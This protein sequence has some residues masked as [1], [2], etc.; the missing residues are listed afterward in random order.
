MGK[1]KS[2]KI[3]EFRK[4]RIGQELKINDVVVF[5]PPRYKGILL[6]KVIKFTPKGVRVQYKHQ[7]SI[8]DTALL[9]NDVVKL[10][11]AEAI[12]YILKKGGI[13]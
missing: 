10:D 13:S 7:D 6:G 2:K 5:N 12:M 4:D 11:S 3:P 1:L 8:E 9:E